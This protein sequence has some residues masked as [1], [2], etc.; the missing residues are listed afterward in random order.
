MRVSTPRIVFF[1]PQ[2][3]TSVFSESAASVALNDANSSEAGTLLLQRCHVAF[4]A[5]LKTLGDERD[6]IFGSNIDLFPAPVDLLSPDPRFTTNPIIESTTICLLQL[7]R[8][9]SGSEIAKA[10]DEGILSNIHECA[11][12]SSG[13]LPAVVVATSPTIDTFII[14]AVEAYRLAFWI[15]YRA[16]YHNPLLTRVAA[17]GGSS[18]LVVSGTT[19][20]RI[21]DIVNEL[22]GSVC[23]MEY[24]PT[25]MLTQC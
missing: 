3:S 14:N 22:R 15:G 13:I 12:Y 6:L 10:R 16:G 1:G 21:V 24:S 9:I 7:L 19:K 20:Q 23:T 2:G 8:Y 11:G 18:A 4:Q 17:G 5:E 25:Y